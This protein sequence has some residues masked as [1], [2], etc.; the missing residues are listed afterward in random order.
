M[1]RPIHYLAR[2]VL[3]TL[4]VRYSGCVWTRF[5]SPFDYPICRVPCTLV[6]GGTEWPQQ[7]TSDEGDVFWDNLPLET[8]YVRMTMASRELEP[9]VPW[10]REKFG[11]NYER[12]MDVDDLLGP[13]DDAHGI[14][15]RLLGLGFDCG[16]VDGVV[17]PKTR[18][19]LGRFR[20]QQGLGEGVPANEVYGA[21]ADLFGG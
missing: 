17:G 20:E 21:L 7:E 19:A 18:A 11:I 10:M 9:V 16:D 13:D 6:G 1:E 12:L 3:N 14:Q 5:V 15:V 4:Q 2:H 8:Y